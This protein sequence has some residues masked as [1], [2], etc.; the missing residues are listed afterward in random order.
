MI[1][2]GVDTG[3]TFYTPYSSQSSHYDVVPTLV[4]VVIVGFSSIATG[5]RIS[6]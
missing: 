4:G 5:S 3:W 1:T 2:D 6:W